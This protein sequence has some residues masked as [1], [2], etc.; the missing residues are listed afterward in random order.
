MLPNKQCMRDVLRFISENNQ[1]K[2][3]SG[4]FY[5]VDI[6]SLN[7]STLLSQMSSEKKYSAQE[8]AYNFFQCYYNNFVIAKINYKG[9]SV[10]ASSLS[11]IYGV[12]LS[13]IDFMN[14]K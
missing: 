8:I 6:S 3:D 10:V 13:G 14:Q 5:D 12:T 9:Q 7:L 1:V 11:D 2:V 4:C